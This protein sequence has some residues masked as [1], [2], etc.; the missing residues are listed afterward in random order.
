MSVKGMNRKQIISLLEQRV[1]NDNMCITK[2]DM[3]ALFNECADEYEPDIVMGE[4]Y[5]ILQKTNSYWSEI[6]MFLPRVGDKLKGFK[7]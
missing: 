1:R 7:G 3:C 6:R 5:L 4:E 2:G